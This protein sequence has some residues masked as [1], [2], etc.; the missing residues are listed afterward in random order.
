[1]A[2]IL[3]V[4][5]N[6]EHCELVRRILGARGHAVLAAQDAESGMEVA[7]AHTPDLILLDMGLPDVD[8]PT[9]VGLFRRAPGLENVPIVAVTAWPPETA[10]TMAEAY[11][12]NGYISKPIQVVDFANRIAGYLHAN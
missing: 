8:G 1:M 12:C 5:D 7:T 11:G 4:D 6:P 10:R 2:T 9:L 3:V